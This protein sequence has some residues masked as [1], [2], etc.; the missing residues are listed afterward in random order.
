[1]S[2]EFALVQW[3]VT[4]WC[5]GYRPGKH[6]ARVLLC[7]FCACSSNLNEFGVYQRANWNVAGMQ[8]TQ[9]L[10]RSTST[11]TTCV[12]S[13]MMGFQ[14]VRRDTYKI[15]FANSTDDVF[16]GLVGLQL[17][18]T[19]LSRSLLSVPLAFLLRFS[20]LTKDLMSPAGEDTERDSELR[21]PFQVIA[22]VEEEGTRTEKY[23]G[24]TEKYWTASWIGN[25]R[26]LSNAK[27]SSLNL[28][29]LFWLL[30]YCKSSHHQLRKLL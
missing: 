13:A 12:S 2:M 3:L 6:S 29:Q 24:R 4:E 20:T 19:S 28:S 14:Y 15:L 18:V 11:I 26:N 30:L 27:Y 23:A 16:R 7:L 17:A 10:S 21:C 5:S 1:M 22:S 9:A 8:R 25:D